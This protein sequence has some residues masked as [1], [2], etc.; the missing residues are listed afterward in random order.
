MSFISG[1][2][3]PCISAWSPKSVLPNYLL[4]GSYEGVYSTGHERNVFDLYSLQNDEL[5]KVTFSY[6]YN[7]QIITLFKRFYSYKIRLFRYKL[8]RLYRLLIP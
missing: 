5:N 6:K 8:H 1:V 4:T 7:Y 2:E 3:D